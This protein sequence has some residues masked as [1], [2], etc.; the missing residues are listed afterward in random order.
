MPVSKLKKVVF[1]A[2]LGPITLTISPEAIENSSPCTA[3]SP[4]N[5]FPSSLVLRR[6]MLQ[7]Q[8]VTSFASGPE[9][10][11]PA[12]H[13]ENQRQAKNKIAPTHE[14]GSEQISQQLRH[15]HHDRDAKQRAR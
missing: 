11:R 12:H 7:F 10:L 8:V 5:D 13:D 4:P 9:P 1:P 15:Q 6:I 14:L 2:P 3:L